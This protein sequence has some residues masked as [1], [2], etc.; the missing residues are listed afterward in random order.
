MIF[1][2][3]V[4]GATPVAGLVTTSTG[5]F[6]GTTYAGGSGNQGT[7]FSFSITLGRQ[8]AP[9]SF[10]RKT[11]QRPPRAAVIVFC[12]DVLLVAMRLDVL[13]GGFGGMVRGM[14][15]MSLRQLR[16]VCSSLMVAFFM[17]FGSFP[18]MIGCLVMMV[19]SLSVVVR[20]FL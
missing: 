4:D 19:G 10:L 15:M 11:K 1:R 14:S 20:S 5:I 2:A 12:Q 3:C 16:V 17:M 6:Y 13:L 7:V 8:A 9:G 18:V